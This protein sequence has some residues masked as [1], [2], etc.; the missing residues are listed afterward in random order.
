V[1]WAAAPVL[2]NLIGAVN[3]VGKAFVLMFVMLWLRWTFPRVRVDQIVYI[4]MKVLVPFGIV[5]LVGAAVWA[6]IPWGG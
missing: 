5:C 6:L 4:C 2:A 1:Y 3:L